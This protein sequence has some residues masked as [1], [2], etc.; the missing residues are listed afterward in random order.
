MD[1]ARV[2]QLAA[3]GESLTVEFKSDTRRQVNDRTVYENV[4]CFAN[5]DGGVLLI[6]VDDDGHITGARFRHDGT[7]NPARL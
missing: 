7:T 4:V 2:R 3:E 5:S 1:E 6:G